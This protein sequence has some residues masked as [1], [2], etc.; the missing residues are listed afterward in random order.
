MSGPTPGLQLPPLT[1]HLTR[2]DLVRYAGASGDFNPIHFSDHH[3]TAVGLPGVIAHGMLTMGVC[4]RIV[5]AWTGDPGA[6]IDYRARFTRPVI[7]GD[8]T[9]ADI[10]VTATV[11]EV[12]HHAGTA[13]VDITATCGGQT[14]LAAC[15]ALVKIS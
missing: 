11:A 1:V 5:T 7:V 14:V 10:N 13:R 12:D 9:G 2:Q 15:R 8:E 6:I 4:S 3:A